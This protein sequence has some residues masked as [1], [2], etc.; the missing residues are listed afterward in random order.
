MPFFVEVILPLSLPKTFNYSITEDEYYF[1]KKGMRVAVPFKNNKI[2]T[3][4][5]VDIHLNE[6][7]LY[8]AREIDQIIDES[9]IVSDIQISHWKWVASYYMC[10]IGDVFRSAMPS[11]LI[12]ES[13]TVI[14][15]K[16]IDLIDDSILSDD[17]FLV[18]EALRNQPSLR[19]ADIVGILNRKNV[20]P[21]IQKLIEKG[22]LTVHEELVETYKPKLVRYVRLSKKY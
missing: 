14:S 17:E 9:P 12:L 6:P 11:A 13:E 22:A 18:C 19:I 21:I 10:P 7:L 5:V 4:L 8:Q 20:L 3:A 1:L 15:R 2:Y 16:D